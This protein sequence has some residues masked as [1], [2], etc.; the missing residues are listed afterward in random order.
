MAAT[1][2]RP[3]QSTVGVI[4][5]T[6]VAACALWSVAGPLDPPPGPVTPTGKT[7]QEIFDKAAA[8]EPRVPLSAATTPGNAFAISVINA[9]GSY[10]LTQDITVPAGRD[11]IRLNASN[12]TVD[13][14]G[15]SIIGQ[16]GSSGGVEF[17]DQATVYNNIVVRN[18]N[19]R[20]M[21]GGG[22]TLFSTQAAG[23][24][25]EGIN[26]SNNAGIG[27]LVPDSST[28]LNRTSNF[29]SGGGFQ[30]GTSRGGV[31]ESCTAVGNSGDGFVFAGAGT[32]AR[33]CFARQNTG[34]GFS[35]GPYRAVDCSAT[36]NGTAGVTAAGFE[37][38]GGSHFTG[39]VASDNFGHGFDVSNNSTVS[40]CRAQDNTLEGI[41]A[42]SNCAITGNLCFSNNAAGIRINGNTVNGNGRGVHV[43]M[44]RNLIVRNS[45]A[46]NS[47]ANHDV[48]IN[49][50]YGTIVA[51][52]AAGGAVVFGNAA[53]SNLTTTDP[54]AN[55][56]H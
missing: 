9:P 3:S 23:A 21:G 24:R 26:A 2:S 15:F 45:A 19:V 20:S 37:T 43:T 48:S 32:V 8:A 29:N 54:W 40:G 52:N 6:L 44:D 4:A 18:G 51:I 47:A 39:C 33:G 50:R 30:I 56:A 41:R 42:S 25:V 38:T 14:N 16:P 5:C 49:N 13:L 22:V 28:T 55:L 27:I 1:A 7:T 35:G 34:A 53:V 31:V 46:G 11:G 12:V 17:Q 10:I 36:L